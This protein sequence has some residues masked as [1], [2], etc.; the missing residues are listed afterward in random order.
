MVV[1]AL[2][3]SGMN[4]GELCGEGEEFGTKAN[5]ATATADLDETCVEKCA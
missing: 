3:G 1:F 2:R 4:E 5:I